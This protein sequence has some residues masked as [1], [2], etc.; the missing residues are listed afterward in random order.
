MSLVQLY[1][2]GQGEEGA[3]KQPI[4]PKTKADGV[5]IVLPNIDTN[6]V[7]D[8][9]KELYTYV[10]E[11]NQSESQIGQININVTYYNSD[12]DDKAEIEKIPPQDWA[13]DFTYPTS[14]FPYAWKRTAITIVDQAKYIYEIVATADRDNSQLIYTAISTGDPNYEFIQKVDNEGN[15]LYQDSQGN[16]GPM[17]EEKTD[18]VYDIDAMND[19]NYLPGKT[20]DKDS[21]WS[22]TPQPISQVNSRLFVGIRFRDSEGKWGLYQGPYLY[23]QWV[24]DTTTVFKYITTDLNSGIPGCNRKAEDPSITGYTWRDSITDL[25]SD[26]EGKI[27]MMSAN[28]SGNTFIYNDTNVW[29]SPSIMSI[30]K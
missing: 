23:S 11:M 3:N 22:F 2:A 30:V 14:R 13:I 5:S 25:A 24:Y 10:G 12:T 19:D 1:D 18:P 26:F 20:Q 6:N 27:W 28:K 21:I 7:E 16:V 9:I 15:P 8:C 17:D 4:Y 29:S